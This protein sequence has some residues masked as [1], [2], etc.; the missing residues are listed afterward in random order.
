MTI[1][2]NGTPDNWGITE[3]S[4]TNSESSNKALDFFVP[5]L[6]ITKNCGVGAGCWPEVIYHTV[7]GTAG[8]NQNDNIKAKFQLSDGSIW[9][10]FVASPSCTSIKGSGQLLENV[11]ISVDVDINGFKGPAIQGKDYFSFYVSKNGV[12]PQGVPE[13]DDTN[14]FE[15]TCLLGK[16]TWLCTAWVIYNENMGYLHC[17]DLSWSGKHKCGG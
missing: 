2:E 16:R 6:K 10:I 17:N 11:C 1:Q 7:D 3:D 12:I 13:M 8:T 14:K 4:S 5:F 9:T 15:N